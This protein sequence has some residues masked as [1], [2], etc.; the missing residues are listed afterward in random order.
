MFKKNIEKTGKSYE[1]YRV[2]LRPL[3]DQMRAT[4]RMIEQ[5]L[6]NKKPLDQKKLLR[7]KEEILKPLR[8]VRQSLEQNKMKI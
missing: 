7:S 5:H 8:V 2:F 6:V 3:R 4:H 1:P